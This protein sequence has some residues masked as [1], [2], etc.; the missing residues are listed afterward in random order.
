MMNAV[1]FNK[2]VSKH[3]KDMSGDCCKINRNMRC[4]EIRSG[5]D[6]KSK[7]RRLIET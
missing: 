5:G 6:A 4:I 1:E 3:C 7:G 2:A